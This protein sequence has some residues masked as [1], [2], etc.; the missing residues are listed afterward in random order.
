[1][2]KITFII[3]IIFIIF[4]P[5][6][7]ALDF[8]TTWNPFTSNFDYYALYTSSDNASVGCLN[9][10]GTQYCSWPSGGSNYYVFNQP[11]Y[12]NTATNV[13][14]NGSA[15]N[16]NGSTY[17]G[18]YATG[19]QCSDVCVVYN[20]TYET[21][22]N[23]SYHSAWQDILA[24]R[25]AF[26]ATN[27]TEEMQ[28]AVGE[29]VTSS[30]GV[31]MVYIDAIPAISAQWDCSDLVTAASGLYCTGSGEDIAVNSTWLN[32]SGRISIYNASYHDA[33]QDI[34]AN[35]TNFLTTYNA[36]YDAKQNDI[37]SDC[38]AGNYTYGVNDDGTLKCREDQNTGGT[39]NTT[40]Q[41]QDATGAAFDTTLN[42]TDAADRM[43]MNRTWLSASGSCNTSN[44]WDNL[45]TPPAIWS[46]QNT[47]EEMQDAIG[48]GFDATLNYTDAAN[49]LGLNMTW[50]NASAKVNSS[51]HWG[52]FL[53]GSG[54]CSNVCTDSSFNATY[55]AKQDDIGA[56][57]AAGTWG[58]GVDD[59]G[60]M[61]CSAP[62]AAD[63]DP[64]TYPAG[65]YVYQGNVTAAGI[66]LGDDEKISAGDSEH[67]KSYFNGTCWRTEVGTTVFAVCP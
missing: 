42:Y 18:G 49:K 65:N 48:G 47:T 31:D 27:T 8:W 30:E 36:T 2:K 34:L 14:F 57:C 61:D 17:W 5:V 29:I 62:T 52:N 40:E 35:R 45:D 60:T 37:G 56:D 39:G 12:N 22:Y 43:G 13:S 38:G 9:L 67:A 6:A 3:F 59:D 28:D 46:T 11:L 58:K 50:L 44:Y 32:D 1:M 19:G 25:T 54:A 23:F 16:V 21:N 51:W 66:K 24:N 26:L 7:K 15:A 41:M 4:I 63:V 20:A 53:V 55:A 33:W 64:G 10:S